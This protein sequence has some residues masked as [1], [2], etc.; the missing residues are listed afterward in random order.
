M[1]AYDFSSGFQGLNSGIDTL[2]QSIK[3]QNQRGTL[4]AIGQKMQTDPTGAANIAMGAGL[5]DL[6][7]SLIKLGQQRASDAT[8]ASKYGAFIGAGSQAA[9]ATPA[10]PAPSVGAGAATNGPAT[11][12]ASSGGISPLAPK[13]AQQFMS[14]GTITNP[15]GA[16]ALAGGIQTES[17]FDPSQTAKGD[18]S[19]GSDS[20]NLAQWNGSRAIDFR[21]FYQANKFDPMD[22]QTGL[23]FVNYELK[24]KPEYAGVVQG[25]NAATTPEEANAAALGYF[26]PAGYTKAN[27]QGADSWTKRLNY[28]RAISGAM[29]QGAGGAP[30]AAA[31]A[32]PAQGASQAGVQPNSPRLGLDGQPV[33]PNGAAAPPVRLAS[34]GAMPQPDT[35]PVQ[36]APPAPIVAA[37]AQPQPQGQPAPQPGAA[38]PGAPPAP[39]DI[40][41]G[42]KQAGINPTPIGVLIG[43]KAGLPTT[44][45]LL[46]AV[47]SAPD[48][49]LSQIFPPE[50]MH[51][52]P[53]L[54]T[55]TAGQFYSQVMAAQGGGT[56]PGG[57]LSAVPGAAPAGGA[58]PVGAMSAPQLGPQAPQPAS[59]APNSG[60][61]G[62]SASKPQPISAPVSAPVQAAQAGPAAAKVPQATAD[63]F[64]NDNPGT[65]DSITVLPD[66]SLQLDGAEPE[67]LAWAKEHAA[68]PQYG[69]TQDPN[70][71][72][73][74]MAA[75]GAAPSPAGAADVSRG[76]TAPPADPTAD[77]A[78]KIMPPGAA[79]AVAATAPGSPERM[80]MLSNLMLLAGRGS[81]PDVATRA[82]QQLIDTERQ[83]AAPFIPYRAYVAD[84]L[85]R[86]TKPE[87]IL[88]LNAWSHQTIDPTKWKAPTA[89][90]LT[91]HGIDP[92][93]VAEFQISSNGELKDN[94]KGDQTGTA[95]TFAA[96]R[97][98]VTDLGMDPS[99]PRAQQ[100]MLTGQM[101]DP[102]KF[103]IPEQKLIS[104][105]DDKNTK[106]TMAIGALQKARA[107]LPNTHSGMTSGLMTWV[108]RND[109]T[110]IVGNAQV[111]AN[112]TEYDNLV[113]STALGILK[114]IFGGRVT[115]Y[116]DQQYTALQPGS[117]KSMQEKD[118]ILGNLIDRYTSQQKAAQ[119]KLE[120]LQ[121]K[122]YYGATGPGGAGGNPNAPQG[123]NP[124]VQLQNSR[125]APQPQAQPGQPDPAQGA[126]A[127][128]GQPIS[129]QRAAGLPS[130]ARF[131]GVGPDGQSHTYT[132]H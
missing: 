91:Q 2:G 102:N 20:V 52:S 79:A 34:A 103:S 71:P 63:K 122:K 43:Q 85:S 21:N 118:Q 48:T 74:F 108:D 80:A 8:F 126:L 100:F 116:E 110:G 95:A 49:P 119:S 130:G 113:Q 112:T 1:A 16:A 29:A 3:E 37:G 13:A 67:A 69:L 61:V 106:L 36:G 6:G 78:K 109:P 98:Q 125:G 26:A 64:F 23:A 12:Q 54:A 41:A 97:K 4:A 89:A 9:P 132:K 68:D 86:G 131:V 28:T 31:A 57:T 93:R 73:H 90:Q 32:V 53:K 88:S 24:N 107:L 45:K 81:N 77:A 15:L 50:I 105:R 76:T 101:P 40:A 87:D 117:G 27:P 65:A 30:Q 47:Q 66:G 17:H 114:E 72:E 19:D 121:G 42:L 127:N 84:E 128:N 96:R 56:Q 94:P 75:G 70:D 92:S 58:P 99:D 55:M 59:G 82:V 38:P 51:G 60:S 120:E 123:G 39:A 7:M 124:S 104:E 5:P 11:P 115:N 25:L 111:G 83:N 129:P 18:G 33:G 35:P 14:N 22:P 44:I 10:T 62:Y 46:T